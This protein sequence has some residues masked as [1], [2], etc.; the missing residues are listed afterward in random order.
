M[1]R[2]RQHGR[3][4]TTSTRD[5]RNHRSVLGFCKQLDSGK[6]HTLA[7]RTLSSSFFFDLFPL[8]IAP[9]LPF[10]AWPRCGL[11]SVTGACHINKKGGRLMEYRIKTCVS[12]CIPTKRGCLGSRLIFPTCSDAN[13]CGTSLTENSPGSTRD[14][15]ST[16]LL[17]FERRIQHV[18]TY[19]TIVA[20]DDSGSYDLP[21][22]VL[23]SDGTGSTSHCLHSISANCSQHP[24]PQ[25]QCDPLTHSTSV[26]FLPIRPLKTTT[27]WTSYEQSAS[28]TFL[29]HLFHLSHYLAHHRQSDCYGES[30]SQHSIPSP[31]VT[32]VTNHLI[33]V[34]NH[35]ASATVNI[36]ILKS[37][38][39]F[40]K[41]GAGVITSTPTNHKYTNTAVI[42]SCLH[43]PQM[44][45]AQT[46]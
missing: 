46:T 18:E 12:Y 33:P 44:K 37:F 45:M 39:K 31:P 13:H 38:N 36:S 1:I 17:G 23:P 29:R 25:R 35:L 40:H 8:S 30:L 6:Q 28:L 19:T 22:L 16:G 21:P 14:P 9:L 42:T 5:L 15:R 11:L 41:T 43:L 32:P 7:T 2:R 27:T 10:K 3:T 20:S 34:T 4:R 26:T 24:H